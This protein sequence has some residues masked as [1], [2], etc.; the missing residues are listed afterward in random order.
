[1]SPH[2]YICLQPNSDL[3]HA[4][5]DFNWPV[6]ISYC[7]ATQRTTVGIVG[8]DNVAPQQY[9]D[10]LDF[11]RD[12]REGLV[13]DIIVFDPT[14]HPWKDFEADIRRLG[15]AH[16]LSFTSRYKDAGT[17]I[18]FS[19]EKVNSATPTVPIITMYHPTPPLCDSLLPDD[20]DDFSF[21]FKILAALEI[22]AFTMD[23]PDT[24]PPMWCQY[25]GTKR[26]TRLP[27]L[28]DRARD[29]VKISRRQKYIRPQNDPAGTWSDLS[30]IVTEAEEGRKN[31]LPGRVTMSAN[32]MARLSPFCIVCGVKDN[33]SRCAGCHLEYY[34]SRN[35]HQ[36][37]DWEHHKAWFVHSF[38]LV[39]FRFLALKL[40]PPRSFRCTGAKKNRTPN[41][42]NT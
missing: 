34:C 6:L 3:V 14:G 20:N 31:G 9:N 40:I 26:T 28:S 17:A 30:G 8:Q 39:S 35:G 5:G 21:S 36:A 11:L 37:E 10:H 33:L 25:D 32:L 41:P 13:I 16:G 42:C 4:T 15:A 24:P 2:G 12:G 27:I 7:K 18:A 38:R 29:A 23:H 19:V 22:S 1:M